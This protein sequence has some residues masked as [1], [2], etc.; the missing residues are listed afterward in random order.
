MLSTITATMEDTV[1]STSAPAPRTPPTREPP[2]LGDQAGKALLDVV[3]DV[4]LAQLRIAVLQAVHVVRD[5][6]G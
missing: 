6:V 3:L 4:E 1:L 5:L 2:P